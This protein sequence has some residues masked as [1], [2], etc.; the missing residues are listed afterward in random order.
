MSVESG[1]NGMIGRSVMIAMPEQKVIPQKCKLRT[2]RWQKLL[3]SVQVDRLLR[4]NP[5]RFSQRS[6]RS[7]GRSKYS[8][9]QV[10]RL[11]F[12]MMTVSPILVP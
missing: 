4:P 3:W 12:R 6:K 2:Q 11:N 5:L 10:F 1:T 9:L 8:F 7:P